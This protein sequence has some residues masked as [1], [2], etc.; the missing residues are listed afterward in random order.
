MIKIKKRRNYLKQIYK[1]NPET[2]GYIIEVSLDD[3]NE[4]FNGW[5]PS[6]IR[7]RDLEP[8]LL[9]FIEQCAYDIP[10]KH[11]VELHF[12]LPKAQYDE[13]KE[14]LTKAGIVN[15]FKFI[16][17]FIQKE[18]SSNRRKI[19]MYIMMSFS[20]L[21]SS[22]LARQRIDLAFLTTT[23]VEG[24]FIGGWVFLWEAFSLFFFTGQEPRA[25]LKRYNRFLES[26]INF[27]YI[28]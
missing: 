10:L 1:E 7:R 26:S 5:D 11:E 18:L 9:S 22:Y 27:Y 21:T 8:D 16:I 20:F 3:Y 23:I 28:D 6:P 24:L 17:H 4:V 25:R 19:F 2:N 13:K 15:N 14:E 12:Y